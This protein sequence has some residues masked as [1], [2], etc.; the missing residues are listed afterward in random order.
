MFHVTG[1]SVQKNIQFVYLAICKVLVLWLPWGWS[2]QSKEFPV[3]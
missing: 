2:G 3:R 1:M